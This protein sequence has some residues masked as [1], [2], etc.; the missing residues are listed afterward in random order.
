MRIRA[1]LVLALSALPVT[2]RLAAG[3]AKPG[4]PRGPYLLRQIF[5]DQPQSIPAVWGVSPGSRRTEIP[6][7]SLG[8]EST[9]PDGP[10]SFVREIAGRATV[11]FVF[12]GN[13]PDDRLDHVTVTVL[14]S[15]T[16]NRKTFL[17][18][19][20]KIFGAVDPDPRAEP[21]LAATWQKGSVV[22]RHFRAARFFEVTLSRPRAG[23]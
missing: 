7:A 20:D 22:L 4:A 8:E 2:T 16:V 17:R 11:V 23:V 5:G 6:P 10:N 3:E 19:L 18:H 9:R 14:E 21:D 12:D 13:G 1:I 15:P